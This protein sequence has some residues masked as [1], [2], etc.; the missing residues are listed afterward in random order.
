MHKPIALTMPQVAEELQISRA[1]A[2][3]L[4]A[5]GLPVFRIG[6]SL[7]V[8]RKDLEAWV[9]ERKAANTLPYWVV[10]AQRKETVDK[11]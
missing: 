9:E 4:K 11:R 1:Q 2:Y 10:A 8:L 3:N 7:R 6:R 5:H